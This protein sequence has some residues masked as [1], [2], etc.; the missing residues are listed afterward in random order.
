[1]ATTTLL[2]LVTPEALVLRE[3]IAMVVIPGVEGDMGVMADHAPSVSTLRPG[4]VALHEDMSAAPI[5]RI[6]VGGG[7]AEV[8]AERCIILAEEAI[9]LSD[10]SAQDAHARQKDA[11]A[12]LAAATSE[13]DKTQAQAE[14]AIAQAQ[15]AA[16]TAPRSS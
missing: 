9:D 13:G 5:R 8:T 1:M 11:E 10:L 15:V 4:L 14:L 12:A 16:L 6:F 7:V 2:E 3:A